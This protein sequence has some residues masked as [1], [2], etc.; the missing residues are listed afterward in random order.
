MYDFYSS[1]R[2][3]LVN[4]ILEMNSNNWVTSFPWFWKV[5]FDVIS[6]HHLFHCISP[7]PQYMDVQK[8]FEKGVNNITSFLNEAGRKYLHN[9]PARACLQ[10]LSSLQFPLNVN[11]NKDRVSMLKTTVSVCISVSLPVG[12][13]HIFPCIDL[14]SRPL[15]RNS[16]I[17]FFRFHLG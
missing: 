5:Y 3:N 13:I 10:N 1:E 17:P 11:I 4:Q 9:S 12:T 2:A 7:F 15:K 14:K 16:N 6:L 8:Y